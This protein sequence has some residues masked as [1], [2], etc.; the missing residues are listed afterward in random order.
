MCR[1]HMLAAAR[2]ELREDVQGLSLCIYLGFRVRGLGFG[3]RV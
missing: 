3:F 2:Q 1:L